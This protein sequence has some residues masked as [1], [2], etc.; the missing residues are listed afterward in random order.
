M[1]V[2]LC[3]HNI[4]ICFVILEY[5]HSMSFVT[6]IHHIDMPRVFA[7]HEYCSCFVTPG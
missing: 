4:Y 5:H 7:D 2:F 3:K 1:F 6:S